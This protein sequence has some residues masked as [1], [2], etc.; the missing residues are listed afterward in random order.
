MVMIGIPLGKIWYVI[1][2]VK[3][4][5]RNVEQEVV[6]LRYVDL[7]NILLMQLMI[8]HHILHHQNRVDHYV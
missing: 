7:H 5:H 1:H 3:L 4:V 8:V 2:G 6:V